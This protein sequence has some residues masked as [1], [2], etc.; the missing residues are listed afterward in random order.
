MGCIRLS[1]NAGEV[2]DSVRFHKVS[3]NSEKFV[4]NYSKIILT[5]RALHRGVDRSLKV[6]GGMISDF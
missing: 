5:Q 3:G 2:L 4:L 1:P 6:G